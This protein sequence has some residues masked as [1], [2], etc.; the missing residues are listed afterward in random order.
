MI[1]NYQNEYIIPI[2]SC[3]SALVFTNLGH[4]LIPH[5][6]HPK[7]LRFTDQ[8]ELQPPLHFILMYF[9]GV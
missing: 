8:L 1:N 9:E 3:M 5:L 4:S 7:H 6:I 2:Y